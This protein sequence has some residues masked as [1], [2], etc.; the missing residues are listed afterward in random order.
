MWGI[1]PLGAAAIYVCSWIGREHGTWGSRE[2]WAFLDERLP[3]G[4]GEARSAMFLYALSV[5]V[6]L[7]VTGSLENNEGFP[8][9]MFSAFTAAFYAALLTVLT[10]ALTDSPRRG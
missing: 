7:G 6:W 3:R 5:F 1:F 4:F 8:S 2:Q 10:A 9:G